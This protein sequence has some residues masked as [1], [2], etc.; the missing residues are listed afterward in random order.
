MANAQAEIK[1]GYS[2]AMVP[3]LDG[4]DNWLDF[5]DGIETFLIMG[6][7][8]DWLEDHRDTPVNPSAEWKKKH[9]FAIYAMRARS[10]YNAKQ[11]VDG[12]INYYTAYETLEKNYKPQG[13]GT[14]REL[15]DRFFTISLADHKSIEDYT[16]AIKKLQ[17]Q[18]I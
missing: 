6:S 11:M 8:F 16:E 9:K 10:N 4:A 13:D 14:F 12:I 2:L 7:Q 17:N 1:G 15:S 3:F 5:S 18:L